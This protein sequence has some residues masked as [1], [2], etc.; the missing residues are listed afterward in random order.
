MGW[1]GFKY[2]CLACRS[3]IRWRISL[4]GNR[5]GLMWL[6]IREPPMNRGAFKNIICRTTIVKITSREVRLAKIWQH[7]DAD[8]WCP[9][10]VKCFGLFLRN[11]HYHNDIESGTS[12]NRSRRG[13]HYKRYFFSQLRVLLKGYL[14]EGPVEREHFGKDLFVV[15]HQLWLLV[16]WL[17]QLAEVINT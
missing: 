13:K 17:L 1:D 8:I 10:V 15:L 7:W 4:S 16:K 6:A 3:Q 11:A 2:F 12:G 5:K 14:W 9:S